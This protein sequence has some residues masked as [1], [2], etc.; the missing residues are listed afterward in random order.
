MSLVCSISLVLPAWVR[1]LVA[2]KQAGLLAL[3]LAL[4]VVMPV[5][6]QAQVTTVKWKGQE[7]SNRDGDFGV[8]TNWDPEVSDGGPTDQIAEFSLVGDDEY[9]VS[10]SSDQSTYGLRFN[11][12]ATTII[13]F[14]ASGAPRVYDVGFAEFNGNTQLYLNDGMTLSIDSTG[15]DPGL[16]TP[17]LTVGDS[18]LLFVD[19]GASLLNGSYASSIEGTIQNFGAVTL[20]DVSLTGRFDNY[21]VGAASF[22]T[23]LQTGGTI[24]NVE[25]GT[26]NLGVAELTSA[27]QLQSGSETNFSLLKITDSSVFVSGGTFGKASSEAPGTPLVQFSGSSGMLDATGGFIRL[28]GISTDAG[29]SAAAYANGAQWHVAGDVDLGASGTWL[30]NLGTA[31]VLGDFSSATT[32]VYGGILIVSSITSPDITVADGG[33]LSVTGPGGVVGNVLVMGLDVEIGTFTSY[34]NVAGTIDGNVTVGAY[35]DLV[36]SAVTGV[37][38]VSQNGYANVSGTIG[39]VGLVTPHKIAGDLTADRVIGNVELTGGM[40]AVGTVEGNVYQEGGTLA[41]GNSPGMTSIAGDVTLIGG[42]FALELKLGPHVSIPGIGWD[43]IDITGSLSGSGTGTYTLQVLSLDGSDANGALAGW[44]PNLKWE[45]TFL[46]ADGG[47]NGFIVDETTGVATLGTLVL[48]LDTSLFDTANGVVDDLW[49]VRQDG[50]SLVLGYNS[51]AAAVPEPSSF[52]VLGMLGAAGLGVRRWR[53]RKGQA[54]GADVVAQ[55]AR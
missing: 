55:T 9:G 22:S 7:E 11:H 31:N 48:A 6:V 8:G 30:Q 18:N 51:G 28:Q 41:P 17:G 14:F 43:A 35:G 20:G 46:T 24:T 27:A 26:L 38:D 47:I 33:S 50:N 15:L 32:G 49:Y 25:S 54:A 29:T 37:L 4:A 53:R 19:V 44:N 36:A 13:D 42:T 52:A 3:A 1:C 5:S 40:F 39:S 21:G 12:A 16:G 45:W 10:F 23:L 34:V 2:S